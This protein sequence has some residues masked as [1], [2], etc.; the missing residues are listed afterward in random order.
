MLIPGSG[1]CA[2]STHER[3][4]LT[5]QHSG[6]VPVTHT[7]GAR[8]SGAKRRSDAQPSNG[9][10]RHSDAQHVR[11]N[12]AYS[13]RV[14]PNAVRASPLLIAKRPFV[15]I[16]D[17]R[18]RALYTHKR[19]SLTA[20][21]SGPVPV[22]HALCARARAEQSNALTLS[23]HVPTKQRSEATLRR[24]D[25]QPSSGAKRCSD[26]QRVRANQAYSPRA[27][28]SAARASSR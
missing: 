8:A 18:F 10:K 3:R 5:V 17:S 11:A 20:Q 2:L 12:Q 22:T 7:L 24:S 28:P 13:R 4:N 15:S 25:A 1:F 26:A 19:R 14:R 16:P 6:P 27:R 23:A 9:A 21:H